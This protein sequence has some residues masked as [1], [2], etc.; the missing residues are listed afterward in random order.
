MKGIGLW[1]CDTEQHFFSNV[2]RTSCT[3]DIG[4]VAS[5]FSGVAFLRFPKG[6]KSPPYFSV[7]LSTYSLYCTPCSWREAQLGLS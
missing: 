2:N 4:V 1:L 3:I 7:C 5:M 6:K